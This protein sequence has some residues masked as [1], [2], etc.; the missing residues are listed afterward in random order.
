MGN[1]KMP[2]SSKNIP[3]KSNPCHFSSSGKNAVSGR[4]LF[5]GLTSLLV[6]GLLVFGLPL[7]AGLTAAA[8][9]P[10]G[11]PANLPDGVY[12]ILD[13]SNG[14]DSTGH[15]D[16]Y[17]YA[18]R[19]CVSSNDT[20][21]TVS[22]GDTSGLMSDLADAYSVY[23]NGCAIDQSYCSVGYTPF[24][25]HE[26][27]L[28]S[29]MP[30]GEYAQNQEEVSLRIFLIPPATAATPV[31][32]PTVAPSSGC[33]YQTKGNE[34]LV[35]GRDVQAGDIICTPASFMATLM[36][37]DGT[38]IILDSNSSLAI[39]SAPTCF[40][41]NAC[42]L[43]N[44]RSGWAHFWHQLTT[45][46]T[47]GGP[48]GCNEYNFH[49]PT[50]AVAV[51]GTDFEVGYDGQA[52]TVRVF[53]GVVDVSDPQ[54]THT[55]TL[56]A[57]QITVVAAN[58]VPAPATTFDPSQVD[59]WWLA[60]AKPSSAPVAGLAVAASII[61]ILALVLAVLILRRRR[62]RAKLGPPT[63]PGASTLSS[64]GEGGLSGPAPTPPLIPEPPPAY[65]A[66]P[67]S[68]GPPPAY[69]PP[70]GYGPYPLYP[71]PPPAR[72]FHKTLLLIRLA[73]VMVIFFGTFWLVSG[74][75]NAPVN[76]PTATLPPLITAS[77]NASA[78]LP[79]TPAPFD[80]GNPTGNDT[81]IEG[82]IAKACASTST[83][84]A[85]QTASLAGLNGA[86]TQEG[87]GAL[88]LPSG[89]WSQGYDEQL[90]FLLNGERTARNLPAFQ[91]LY[92]S[93]N[94]DALTVAQT[95]ASPSLAAR[96]AVSGFGAWMWTKTSGYAT[97]VWDVFAGDYY[98]GPGSGHSACT[99]AGQSGCWS[100]REATLSSF[101][102][103]ATSSLAL[104]A[105]C[106]PISSSGS[107]GKHSLTCAWEGGP[108]VAASVSPGGD[109]SND[110]N[111]SSVFPDL[112][113]GQYDIQL[114]FA[115][116][117]TLPYFPIMDVPGC[118]SQ[119]TVVPK[120]QVAG[121]IQSGVV[122]IQDGCKNALSLITC[123]SLLYT[124]FIN[125]AFDATLKATWAPD[126][127]SMTFHVVKT[128]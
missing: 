51:R 117:G 73:A 68:Y 125:G 25:G 16:D 97:T 41:T 56:Q 21:D 8:S 12:E 88:T 118:E 52:T 6:A 11:F 84:A 122:Q 28:L 36:F 29:P 89:F 15:V 85:C 27:D 3:S 106:V 20:G 102:S 119:H 62:A 60:L 108:V 44:L 94:T 7:G 99:A 86:R 113:D 45:C 31:L 120:D 48:E 19:Y 65:Y 63:P 67:P 4:F 91:A 93:L 90:L 61:I 22:G 114:C 10:S 26:F 109:Q 43:L 40:S 32:T 92:P 46:P 80:V 87:L 77:P 95:A 33:T 18:N 116:T 53:E 123:G 100:L 50:V 127:E 75:L 5:K 1:I 112:P 35:V 111:G 107:V 59:H 83:L 76:S 70:P 2:K 98:D 13:C 115:G 81:V 105:A 71:P 38:T 55:V 101:E 103:T 39:E 124:P 57:N 126:W 110:Q 72:R 23:T 74:G 69:Y 37:G 121:V 54:Q 30:P 64:P 78:T 24:D 34:T 49:T 17:L 9:P 79:P 66:A 58:S 128:G 104:G 14:P 82:T 42:L 47:T 96:T